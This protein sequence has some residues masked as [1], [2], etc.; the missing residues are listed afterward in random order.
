LNIL[1]GL[2]ANIGSM[3]EKDLFIKALSTLFFY[4]GSEAPAEVFWGANDLL[5]WFEKEY[6]VQ[7]GIRFDEENPDNYN[8]VIEAIKNS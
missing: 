7:L 3:K 6:N 1:I 5:D 8:D 2:Q 4:W